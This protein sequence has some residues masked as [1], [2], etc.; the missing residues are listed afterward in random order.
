MYQ[1]MP[2][3]HGDSAARAGT[4]QMHTNA[5]AKVFA[6]LIWLLPR[7]SGSSFS[8]LLDFP[9]GIRNQAYLRSS[10]VF[11][12]CCGVQFRCL[13]PEDPELKRPTRSRRRSLDGTVMVDSVGANASWVSIKGA[14]P[15]PH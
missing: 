2:D 4:A 9:P 12:C 11:W 8:A 1:G 13:S 14:P 15:N 6:T 5:I 3:S 7:S 10:R